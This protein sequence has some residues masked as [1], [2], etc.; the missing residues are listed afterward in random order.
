MCVWRLE[1]NL[2]HWSSLPTLFEIGSLAHHC[3]HQASW[4][5][6]YWEFSYLTLPAGI[7]YRH[8]L[9]IRFL[10]IRTQ[11]LKF[12]WQ[13]LHLLSHFQVLYFST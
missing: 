9:L 6:S 5:A 7:I 10:G 8:T 13:A 4:P 3:E 11:V 12:V 2:R 1:D